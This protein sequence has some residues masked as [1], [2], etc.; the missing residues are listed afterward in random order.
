MFPMI[1]AISRGRKA[2]VA[3]CLALP[4]LIGAAAASPVVPVVIGVLYPDIPAPYREVFTQIIAGVRAT[5]GIMVRRYPLEQ[6]ADPVAL[7]RWVRTH[8]CRAVIAL[9]RRGVAAAHDLDDPPVPVIAGAVLIT[10]PPADPGLVGISL[11][12][13][14]ARLFARLRELAPAV[15]RVAVVYN[16]IHSAWLIGRAREAARA[17]GLQLT[18]LGVGDLRAAVDQYRRIFEESDP[19]RLAVWLPQDPTTVDARLVLPLVLQA[20][21]DRDVAVFSSNPAYVARGV[22]FALYPNNMAMGTSLGR[23]ALRAARRR[24]PRAPRL[25]LLRDLSI[26]VNLRTADHLGLVFTG[27]QVQGFDL[28]FPVSR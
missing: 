23:M 8:G 26:A 27:R 12:P 24:R 10:D 1:P 20:A 25:R 15:R 2:L 7:R 17:Q 9:G 11:A 18:A 5:P 14:P 3:L 28:V 4:W 21:W 6:D 13:D 19:G 16:P 22:L